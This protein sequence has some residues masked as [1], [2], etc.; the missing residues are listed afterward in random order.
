MFVVDQQLL[1]VIRGVVCVM[2]I[3]SLFSFL[4]YFILNKSNGSDLTFIIKRV[5]LVRVGG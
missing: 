4:S 2:A 5:L 3:T 1:M